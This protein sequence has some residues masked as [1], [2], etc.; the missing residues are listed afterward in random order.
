M[1]RRFN[2]RKTFE[3]EL[4]GQPDFQT[5]MQDRT[6]ILA[7]TIEAASPHKT[8][9]FARRVRKRGRYRVALLDPFWHLVEYGS[10]NN[11]A[12]APVRRAVRALGL[13][14]EDGRA[15]EPGPTA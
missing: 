14:F 4:R 5:G 2:A 13:R 9:Y 10:K 3:Q 15:D 1:A 12:Y 11:P 7:V 8:G 6:R